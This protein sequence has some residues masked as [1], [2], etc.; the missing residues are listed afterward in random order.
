[1]RIKKRKLIAF[2]DGNPR[3][4]EWLLEVI[5]QNEDVEDLLE[6]LEQ[7]KI[8]FREHILV[9]YLLQKQSTPLKT[10]LHWLSVFELPIPEL[11]LKDVIKEADTPVYLEQAQHLG[12]IDIH[13]YLFNDQQVHYRIAE[14][15]KPLL[16][17]IEVT[18]YIRAAN[19]LYDYW[20]KESYNEAQALEMLRL[21]QKGEQK[22]IVLALSDKLSNR[23]VNNH[24]YRDAKSLC[25]EILISYPEN[26]ELL[27]NLARAE[28]VLGETQKA[29]QS[30]TLAKNCCLEDNQITLSTIQYYLAQIYL[31]RGEVEQALQM[32]QQAS[33]SHY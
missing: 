14:I 1:M 21:A 13:P 30:L 11:V 15:I 23:W 7:K 26:I 24:R 10:I 5:N 16:P 12:L 8:E 20:T 9:E 31:Q 4:Y 6:K 22:H 17:E 2:S 29:E 25:E 33:M 18:Q 19:I 3:L 28:I 32:Y 27:L